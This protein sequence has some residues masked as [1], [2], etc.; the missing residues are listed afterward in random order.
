MASESNPRRMRQHA[1]DDD[2]VDPPTPQTGTPS[3]TRLAKIPKQVVE[4]AINSIQK[5]IS[6]KD[7]DE[8]IRNSLKYVWV[9][10]QDALEQD[11]E[12]R[13]HLANKNEFRANVERE[14]EKNF[15]D[16]LRA[17]AANSDSQGSKAWESLFT[18]GTS[19]SLVQAF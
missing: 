6:S 10:V 15:I 5:Y 17:M 2:R 4:E 14:G 18:D 12:L 9:D 3:K 13:I 7:D 1:Q 19:F 16:S 8:R 11:P